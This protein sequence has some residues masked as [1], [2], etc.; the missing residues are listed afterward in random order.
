MLRIRRTVLM[1]CSP[2]GGVAYDR[3]MVRETAEVRG[4]A[5]VRPFRVAQLID[6]SDPQAVRAAF[7]ALSRT[8]G[9]IHMPVLNSRL[10]PEQLEF[11]GRAFDVD[12]MYLESKAGDLAEWL[13]SSGWG[14]SGGADW[15]PF[16]QHRSYRRGLL[17]ANLVG[18][19]REELL[20]PEWNRADDLDLF[21]T[22]VF[23]AVQDSDTADNDLPLVSFEVPNATRVGLGFLNTVPGL[24]ADKVGVVQATAIG[25][26]VAD[27]RYLDGLGGVVIARTGRPEDLVL[28]WNLRTYG[29]RILCLPDDGPRELLE[30]L[31]RGSV[32]GSTL[33]HGGR[34]DASHEQ[35]LDV[36]GLNDAGSGT[37]TALDAMAARLGLVLRPTDRSADFGHPGLETRFESTFRG[38]FRPTASVG[39]VRTPTV[40]LTSAAGH[41][42]GVVAVELS[43]YGAFGLDP[44]STAQL[45]PYRRH[46][47]LL[48]TLIG[49]VDINHVRIT[50]GGDGVVVGQQASRDE[51]PIGFA[52]HIDGIQ[53][54][55]DDDTMSVEQS[56]E[57]R[58][59]TRAS[60]ML[61][62]P[63]GTLLL[64][65]GVRAVIDKTA[66]SPT[67][68][69]L[70]QLRTTVRN[71]C[72]EWPNAM[73]SDVT[74]KDYAINVVNKLLFSGL[75]VPM[76]DVHCSNCRV[77]SQVSARDLDATIRCEFC[78]DEFKLALSLALSSSKSKW[79]YRLA[80]HLTPQKVT[81]LLPALATAS[82]FGQFQ[83]VEGPEHLHAFGVK[84]S[85][86]G[87]DP[88]EA[89]IVTYLGQ[90]FWVTVLGEVKTSN[91]IDEKDV[92]NLED[93]QCRLD[94]KKVRSL[95]LF[96]T[97]KDEFAPTE[98]RVLR[99][100]VE[101]CTQTT[102][103][104]Q[105]VVP[106]FPLL[107]TGK[108]LSLPW[109][110]EEHPWRWGEDRSYLDG[111]FG[112]AAESCRRNL[113]LLDFEFGH[114]AGDRARI[115]WDDRP[116]TQTRRGR[117]T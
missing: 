89:D 64:H 79:R 92:R 50:A 49:T 44:R 47:K 11:W 31:T 59:Q 35:V 7:V 37:R 21:Y 67:G 77:E 109:S 45:P 36:W 110:H 57:G 55:F 3:D 25:T 51:V 75:F 19:E 52:S 100:L 82:L 116:T 1:S 66:A 6:T 18:I 30:F 112:T 39:M 2:V 102:T 17:P 23:G 60:E 107:L 54:L 22:A 5:M 46:G 40:P 85:P 71:K 81:A 73:F 108:D 91:W 61:G 41:S 38:E 24:T 114:Q 27:R 87:R 33:I 63:R 53:V 29:R 106:R 14:W 105:A 70:E 62:G 97:L 117:R 111:I 95:L 103:A 96:A 90:P 78:G 20:V 113:G 72:G 56:D 88:I 98:V 65:P 84:F 16:A 34:P 104:H 80:S 43:L 15:A 69:N 58:F 13:R 74:P 28:F 94:G 4:R 93:L 8:W 86:S 9:G 26:T 99:E 68:L 115:Q 101:R 32:T 76:L 12:A 42:P 10:T 83:S 48:E